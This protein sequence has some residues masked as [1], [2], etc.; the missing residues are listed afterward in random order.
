M[1]ELIELREATY[2]DCRDIWLWRNNPKIRKNFF[3]EKKITWKEH[4]L[5]FKKKLTD[6]N[7]K[8]YISISQKNKIGVI[9]FDE[10]NTEIEISINLNPKFL[11]HKIGSKIIQLGVIKFLNDVK[12]KKNIAAKI[13]KDNTA[14]IRAFMKAGF[15]KNNSICHES[16]VCLSF[17]QTN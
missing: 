11:G 9:R 8:I 15:S 1:N 16:I 10:L 13:K 14:S 4:E 6:K 7:S 2:S 12:T 17:N 5:W 3:N